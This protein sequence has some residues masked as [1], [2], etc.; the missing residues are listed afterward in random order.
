MRIECCTTLS[1]S[2]SPIECLELSLFAQDVPSSSLL[3]AGDYFVHYFLYDHHPA[4]SF[5][6]GREED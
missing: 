6:L 4:E 1:L 5:C 3:H 2:L